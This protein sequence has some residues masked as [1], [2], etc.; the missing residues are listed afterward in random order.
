MA[1]PGASDAID[2]AFL[3]QILVSELTPTWNS[4]PNEV[5]I[6]A[7]TPLQSNMTFKTVSKY[8][9]LFQITV[10]YGGAAAAKAAEFCVRRRLPT[11]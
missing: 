5:S 1:L 8:N 9:S 11:V 6:F 2:G 3:H 10:I 7:E 4:C